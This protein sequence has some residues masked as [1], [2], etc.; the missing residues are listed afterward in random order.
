MP[1]GYKPVEA[2]DFASLHSYFEMPEHTIIHDY[3][4]LP[5]QDCNI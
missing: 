4:Q 1:D 3:K 2:Q 5:L